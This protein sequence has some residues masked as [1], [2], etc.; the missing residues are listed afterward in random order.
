MPPE[1]AGAGSEQV[2]PGHRAHVAGGKGACVYLDD[3]AGTL[4]L[5]VLELPGPQKFEHG[6]IYIT[7]GAQRALTE[8]D[9]LTALARHLTG[10]WGELDDHDKQ[11][12]ELSLQRGS[13]LLSAYRSAAGDAFWIITEADRSMTTLLLP[14][15]Y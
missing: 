9:V 14:D 7:L 10:D 3:Q 1:R 8:A 4:Q 5:N 15:E 11:E 2:F 13:R 12:N 6:A